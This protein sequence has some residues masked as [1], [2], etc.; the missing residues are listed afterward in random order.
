MSTLKVNKIRDTSGSADAI[1]LDPSGGAVL[2]GVTTISTASITTAKVGAAVTISESGIE[3]S[4]IGITCASINDGQV[5]GRRNMI[6]NGAM[7]IAQRGT[8]FNSIATAQVA[9]DRFRWEQGGTGAVSAWNVTQKSDAAR[10]IGF[11]NSLK[12]EVATVDSSLASNHYSQFKYQIETNDII[13]QSSYG[14]ST[15]KKMTLSFYVKSSVTGTFPLAFNNGNGSRSN[16]HV[17]TI[18]SANTWER[19]VITFVGDTG[20]TWQTQGGSSAGFGI[21]WGLAVG[22]G[23]FGTADGAWAADSSYANLYASYSNALVTT[24]GATWELTGVQLEIGE[25]ATSFEHRSVGEELQ[26]CSRYFQQFEGGSNNFFASGFTAGNDFYGGGTL[27]MG[28]MRA[29]PTIAVDGTLSHLNYT[30]VAVS[31][32]ASSITNQGGGNASFVLRLQST[33]NTTSNAG[34]YARLVNSNTN[35]T[36]DAEI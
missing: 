32:N 14:L 10:E 3:A 24:S 12:V 16:P 18:N 33:T 23:Y 2:A 15:A 5:G 29:A 35:L 36:F 7:Q 1:T 13:K 25:E 11:E 31:A 9:I 21:R 4:G 17:Y 22:S 8:T 30:H 34:A 20:G 27:P 19:K 28:K 6:I 26:L